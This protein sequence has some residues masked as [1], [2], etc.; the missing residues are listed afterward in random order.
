MK[1]LS[2]GMMVCD[3]LISPVP[4]DIMTRDSFG[5]CKP[6]VTCGGDALNV[7]ISSSKLGMDVSIAGRIGNDANGA[8]ILSECGKYRIDTSNVVRDDQCTTATSYALIDD[9]GERH[10]LSHRDIFSNLVFEDINPIQIERADCVYLG[11]AMA[12]S[13]MND[14]GIAE[15]FKAAHIKGKMTVM[16][17]AIDEKQTDCNWFERLSSAFKETDVFFPSYDEAKLI[18]GKDD[19]G[20]IAETFR[21]FGMKAF[22]IKLGS[23]GCYVTNFHEER[24]IPGLKNIRVVDTTGAGDAFMAGLICA[25]SHQFDIF[26][27]AEFANVVAALNIGA[28]GGTAGVPD[29]ETVQQF[30]KNN[31]QKS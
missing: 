29:F 10:F 20:E 27:S 5:I 11:S 8:F 13:S 9:Q 16:D 23:E 12:L 14:D 21:K 4:S 19:P 6:V 2:V 30:L 3:I 1:I 28:L 26:Q 25:L 24:I 15:L 17:A 31:Q 7:A 18:T 22:G